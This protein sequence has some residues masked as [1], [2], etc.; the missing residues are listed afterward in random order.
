M[1]FKKVKDKFVSTF[2][3]SAEVAAAR[4]KDVFGTE[5]KAVV[6][7]AIIGSAGLALA[8]APAAAALGV[9]GVA[10]KAGSAFLGARLPVKAAVVLGAPIAAGALLN[11]PKVATRTVGGVLNLQSNLFQAAKE[12]SFQNIKDVFTEN[13]VLT[14]VLGAVAL[15]AVAAPIAATVAARGRS[16]S[17][18]RDEFQVRTQEM[19]VLP[20]PPPS[21][22]PEA[23]PVTPETQV[24][25]REAGGGAVTRRRKPAKKI[26]PNR[27]TVR[28]NVLNNQQTYIRARRRS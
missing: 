21:S 13:P 3:P 12:P 24:L 26:T 9:R 16:E 5:S 8:A 25:G 4:R 17:R 14:G 19:M 18:S 15:G 11:E 27:M 28:V 10:A 7:T 20:S 2:L 22:L 23:M 6:G 1:V